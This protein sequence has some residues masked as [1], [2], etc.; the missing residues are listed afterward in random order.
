MPPL[1]NYEE[2]RRGCLRSTVQ[3]RSCACFSEVYRER[4]R[5][6]RGRLIGIRGSN[7]GEMDVQLIAKEENQDGAQCR[8][9]EAGWMKSF[10]PRT[11]KHVGNGAPEDRSYDAEN[12]CPKES[13]MDVHY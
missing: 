11:R 10:V 9:N 2:E 6:G 13:H 12:D 3:A 5:E 8:K 4:R 1:A 7:R